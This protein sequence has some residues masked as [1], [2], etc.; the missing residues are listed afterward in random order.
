MVYVKMGQAL[1][2]GQ[3]KGKEMYDTLV[4]GGSGF[5]GHHLCEKLEGDGC[6]VLIIDDQRAKDPLDLRPHASGP[7]VIRDPY[8]RCARRIIANNPSIK[9]VYLL[10]AVSLRKHLTGACADA[11]RA[12]LLGVA[13]LLDVL[14]QAK[15]PGR[16]V[17]VSSSEVYGRARCPQG[18]DGPFL[19]ITPYAI[20]KLAAERMVQYAAKYDKLNA[21]VARPFNLYGPYGHY[22]EKCGEIIPR[23]MINAQ[24]GRSLPVYGSAR[25]DFLWVEDAVNGLV[26]VAEKGVTGM[27][28]P[29]AT[30][31]SYTIGELAK[32]I[33]ALSGNKATTKI[34]KTRPADTPAL[35][36]I[37]ERAHEDLGWRSQVPLD[38]GLQ[39]LWNWY[40]E[41]SKG[42]LEEMAAHIPV[43]AY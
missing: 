7:N 26:L 15:W 40:S 33:Q 18:D 41:F 22:E 14:V 23:F 38:M 2:C 28:Y 8:E 5:F 42:T 9:T 3:H 29:L 1:I 17:F 39:Q 30:G 10:A 32:K 27:A 35:C 4:I 16:L 6:S 34:M 20:S 19:P 36:C 25:R 12:D 11:V 24:L 37:A 21:V 13:E 31:T 43:Q